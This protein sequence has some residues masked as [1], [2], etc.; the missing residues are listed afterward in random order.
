MAE[1]STLEAAPRTGNALR[2]AVRAGFLIK[3]TTLADWCREN[4]IEPSWAFQV[5]DGR[6]DGPAARRLLRRL[7]R[8]AGLP[9]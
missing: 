9:A 4:G 7:S 6:R 5:L 8:A 1:A 3:G 2:H